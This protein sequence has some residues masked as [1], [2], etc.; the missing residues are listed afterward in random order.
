MSSE[1]S[2]KITISTSP[3]TFTGLGTPVNHLTGRK[4]TYKSRIC[5][6]ET[7]N[8]LMPPPTGVVKGPLILTT[9]SRR[10]SKVSSGNHSSLP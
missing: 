3:G 4:H 9:Y 2:L 1:F 5:L 8:D 10:A 7:F 6:N